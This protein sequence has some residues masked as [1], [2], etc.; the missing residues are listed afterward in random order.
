MQRCEIE[1]DI[2]KNEEKQLGKGIIGAILGSMVG[3]IVWAVAYYMGWFFAVIGMLI[4][5]GA[6]KGYELLG[7]KKCKAKVVVILI[8][9]VFGAISVMRKAGKEHSSATLNSTVIE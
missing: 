8:A 4:G 6:K 2:Y 9:T 7:G 1:Q 5:I 3:S